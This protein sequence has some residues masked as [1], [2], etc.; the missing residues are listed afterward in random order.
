MVEGIMWFVFRVLI[1]SALSAFVL[2]LY[3]ILFGWDSAGKWEGMILFLVFFYSV[4][5]KVPR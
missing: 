3:P 5:E 4:S 2:W 1:A